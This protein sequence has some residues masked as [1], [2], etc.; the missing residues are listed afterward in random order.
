MCV[1]HARRQRTGEIW[2]SLKPFRISCVFSSRSSRFA[3]CTE[4][5]PQQNTTSTTKI[6]LFRNSE[7]NTNIYLSLTRSYLFVPVVAETTEAINKDGD[8]LNDLGR[9]ITQ[10]TDDHR[11][12]TF[13]F[14]R[15]SVLIQWHSAVAVLDIFAH[16]TLSMKCRRSS[17]CSS[18]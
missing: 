12:S 2:A 6:I 17:I 1:W 13:L 14:Q 11:E 8:F 7:R 10:S 15:L 3:S 18:F 5:F 16:M 4:P 9:R